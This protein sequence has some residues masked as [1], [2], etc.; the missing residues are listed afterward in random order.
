MSADDKPCQA[1]PSVDLRQQI[2]DKRVPKH[3]R[4]WWAMKESAK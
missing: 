2:M 3:E 1:T 4:E